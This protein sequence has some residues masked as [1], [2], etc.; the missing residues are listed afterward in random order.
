MGV[1][2]Q[3]WK[4][5]RQK[6]GTGSLGLLH[7]K[8]ASHLILSEAQSSQEGAGSSQAAP[9][10]AH[11]PPPPHSP[12]HLISSLPF[13]P[14]SP[15]APQQT[16][17]RFEIQYPISLKGGKQNRWAACGRL[18][19]SFV[20]WAGGEVAPDEPL[21]R[22]L[23]AVPAQLPRPLCPPAP[24]APSRSCRS[25]E[26]LPRALTGL[27]PADRPSQQPGR[28]GIKREKKNRLHH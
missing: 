3:R 23:P 8:A 27:S 13:P 11:K 16:E 7:P 18:P 24:T 1:G 28:P 22:S 25:A 4:A 26:P 2:E 21:P 19:T 17:P 6:R 9:P 12:A 15:S 5:C 10:C 14:A 20:S